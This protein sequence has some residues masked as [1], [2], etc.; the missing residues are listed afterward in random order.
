MLKQVSLLSCLSLAILSMAS[1]PARA[2][3]TSTQ[4]TNQTAAI[5]GDNNT[6]IQVSTQTTSQ[7]QLRGLIRSTNPPVNERS[8][9][10]QEKQK[11]DN[12]G[13]HK[14]FDNPNAQGQQGRGDRH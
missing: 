6:I 7:Q 1:V 9:R 12:P 2:E 8:N 4:V 14:G 10:G 13:K 11:L 3:N 5:V